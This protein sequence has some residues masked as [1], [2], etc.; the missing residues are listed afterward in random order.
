MKLTELE[1]EKI[2]CLLLYF[3]NLRLKELNQN[4]KL[5]KVEVNICIQSVTDLYVFLECKDLVTCNYDEGV[6]QSMVSFLI[7]ICRFSGRTLNCHPENYY[8]LESYL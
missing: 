8:F 2:D 5:I 1:K 3:K 6:C 7:K 4:K